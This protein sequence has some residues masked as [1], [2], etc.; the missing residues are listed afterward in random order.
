MDSEF[1]ANVGGLVVVLRGQS[2]P[3]P[4][5][6]AVATRCT[7]SRGLAEQPLD[8]PDRRFGAALGQPQQREPWLRLVA[9]GRP[10]A[11]YAACG[12]GEVAAD[13]E[14]VA[15]LGHRETGRT[16]RPVVEVAVHGTDRTR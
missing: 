8:R 9:E 13:A 11:S 4:R 7:G 16:W 2:A 14:H 15:A 12:P 10:P 5:L 3:R 1:G 6:A